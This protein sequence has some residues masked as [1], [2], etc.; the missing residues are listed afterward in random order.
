MKI[1]LS[2]LA[3]AFIVTSCGSTYSDEEIKKFD[4][5]IVAYLAKKGIECEKS[6]S[7]LY[8]KI[9]DEGDADARKIQYSDK[10]SFTY[11]GTFLNGKVFDEQT[12]PVEF[13]VK[14]LIGAWKEAVLHVKRGGKIFLVSPP[15]LGYGDRQLDDIPVN[16]ILVYELEVVEV[17]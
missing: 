9:I 2:I 14:V 5:K 12:D 7:G 17:K 6:P 16:S 3:L 4:K 11:K 13:D 10:I 8:Y 1:V 15:N